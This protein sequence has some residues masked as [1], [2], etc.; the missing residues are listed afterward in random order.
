MFDIKSIAVKDT[1]EF[2]LNDANDSPLAAAGKPCMAIIYGPGTK[3]YA[4]AVA[5]RQAKFV[6]RARRGKKQSADADQ[7]LA[8]QAEFLAD[9]TVSLELAYEDLQDRAKHLAIY[10][11]RSIGFIAE[12]VAEKLGDWANFSS[13]SAKS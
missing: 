1:I 3:H 10:S 6:D 5:R 12:Q 11:D 7:V 13:E 8:D 2:A 9:I 4:V